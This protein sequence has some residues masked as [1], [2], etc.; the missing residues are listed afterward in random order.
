MTL[1]TEAYR[2]QNAIMHAGGKFGIRAPEFLS[3]LERYAT[4]LKAETILDYGSGRNEW[5]KAQMGERFI[6]RSYDPA[7]PA[8]S[9]PPVPAHLV[10][11]I[12]VL[13]H[14]EPDCLDAVLD[15]VFNLTAGGLFVTVATQPALKTLPDGRN[16]HLIVQ[17]PAWWLPHLT[18]RWRLLE[19]KDAGNTFIAAMANPA[20]VT[21]K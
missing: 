12:D 17:E 11:C 2:E 6:V 5:V 16:A 8:L 18:A 14:V 7:V 4:A 20:A 10:A 3:R 15:H 9:A 1:I 19:F 21:W 13:E